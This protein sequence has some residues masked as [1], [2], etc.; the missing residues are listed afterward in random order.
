MKSGNINHLINSLLNITKFTNTE[1]KN[2]HPFYAEEKLLLAMVEDTKDL[3]SDEGNSAYDIKPSVNSFTVA[4]WRDK[5][6]GDYKKAKL[7]LCLSLYKQRDLF[8]AAS[9]IGWPQAFSHI[10]KGIVGGVFLLYSD[11]HKYIYGY[12]KAQEWMSSEGMKLTQQSKKNYYR[13]SYLRLWRLL[14]K[15]LGF[16]DDKTTLKV[17]K[18][19]FSVFFKLPSDTLDVVFDQILPEV[20]ESKIV[21]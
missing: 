10:E 8:E 4:A 9:K 3:P 11:I 7:G 18:E 20:R 13:K 14:D 12:E 21:K 16:K 5:N 6:L 17:A 2:T 15:H 19:V 1:F